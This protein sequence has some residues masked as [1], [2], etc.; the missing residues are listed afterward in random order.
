MRLSIDVSAGELVDRITILELK[1]RR[2]PKSLHVELR[3]ELARARGVRDQNLAP[4]PRLRELA[5][6]LRSV[7][8]QLWGI[9][10]ELRAC[11]RAQRFDRGFVQLARNVYILN[12]R[13]AAL[14]RAIDTLVGSDILEHKSHRFAEDP[15][16]PGAV[17]ARA[18]A[19]R[20]A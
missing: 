7:N 20:I 11:E 2:L 6:A 15:S 18:A 14:K 13:R 4:N 12:D 10:E 17:G 8:R 5:S 19:T 1:L 16:S 9:E 3:T